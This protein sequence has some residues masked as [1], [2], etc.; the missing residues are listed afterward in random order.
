[1]ERELWFTRLLNDHFAGAANAI[2]ALFH[3]HAVNPERPWQDFISMQILVALI[4]IVLFAMLRSR[5]SVDR[6][7][8][9]Q[10]LF[11]TLHDFVKDQGEE[12]IGHGSNHY[13]P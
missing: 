13:L 5:L 4:I 1:M 10:Q 11:E 12:I 2:L 8:D 3:V 9:F 6:P 7:G